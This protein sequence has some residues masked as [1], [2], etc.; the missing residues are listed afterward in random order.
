MISGTNAH[1]ESNNKS[2]IKSDM[3]QGIPQSFER[4]RKK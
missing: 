1:A 2:F 4:K 3:P